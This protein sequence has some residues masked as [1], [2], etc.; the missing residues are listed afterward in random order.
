MSFI[1]RVRKEHADL[2]AKQQKLCDF[3]ASENFAALDT[4]HQ[5]LLIAQRGTMETYK[6]ILAL[7]LERAGPEEPS[8]PALGEPV[9]TGGHD[10]D[11]D[12]PLKF[13]M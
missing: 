2:A 8:E 11:R 9:E 6:M 1:S 3:I 4:T 13:D 7:R 12:G 10:I 5:H